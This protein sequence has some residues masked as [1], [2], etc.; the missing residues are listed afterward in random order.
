MKTKKILITLLIAILTFEGGW[1]LFKNYNILLGFFQKKLLNYRRSYI[2]SLVEDKIYY[3]VS[4]NFR[5]TSIAF[6]VTT[7]SKKTVLLAT[8][9]ACDSSESSHVMLLYEKKLL[10]YFPV[11]ILKIGDDNDLCLLE[12]STELQKQKGLEVSAKKDVDLD[13]S[14][15]FLV[16]MSIDKKHSLLLNEGQLQH[17]AI[18]KV[19]GYIIDSEEKAQKCT[20]SKNII[21]PFKFL[22]I[23]VQTCWYILNGR[24]SNL[25]AVP[26]LSG[27]PVLDENGHVI[28]VISASFGKNRA[29]L[30]TLDD[31]QNFLKNY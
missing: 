4:D 14:L 3:L 11:K 28:G 18:I 25:F 30:V 12:P 19:F 1:L 6:L 23:D 7:P 2:L 22:F 21:L 10:S 27:S 20:L 8:A 16:S 15:A 9:H 24:F 13:Q 26:G 31:I 5:T 29:I 17:R